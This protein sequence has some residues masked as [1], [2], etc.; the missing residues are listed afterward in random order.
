MKIYYD[1]LLILLKNNS[2]LSTKIQKFIIYKRLGNT[3]RLFIELFSLKT[4]FSSI[5]LN[6]KKRRQT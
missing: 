4:F 3:I 1:I 5:F 2:Q 6:D